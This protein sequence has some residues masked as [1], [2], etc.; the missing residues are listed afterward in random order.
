MILS[1][2]HINF[3]V[4]WAD[5][6]PKYEDMYHDIFIYSDIFIFSEGSEGQYHISCIRVDISVKVEMLSHKSTE[7]RRDWDSTKKHLKTSSVCHACHKGQ[8]LQIPRSAPV[9]F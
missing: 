1:T 6:D 2:K 5:V 7:I 4:R 8:Q 9:W 3:K